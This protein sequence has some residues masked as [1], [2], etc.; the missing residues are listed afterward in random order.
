MARSGGDAGKRHVP[1]SVTTP[2]RYQAPTHNLSSTY[3]ASVGGSLSA[4][5]SSLTGNRRNRV[6]S[7]AQ[8]LAI[9]AEDTEPL[10]R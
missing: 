2:Y 4:V 3:E 1:T 9:L 5:R 10:R 7:Y 6:F 8:Y